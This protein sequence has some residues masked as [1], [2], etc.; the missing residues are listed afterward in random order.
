MHLTYEKR[1]WSRAG[2]ALR[3]GFACLLVGIMLEYVPAVKDLMVVSVL[4]Y[5]IAVLVS[6]PTLG[7]VIHNALG[8]LAVAVPGLLSTLIVLQVLRPP[9]SKV[10]AVACIGVSSYFITYLSN[11]NLLG[12]KSALAQVSIVY[13]YAHYDSGMNVVTFPLR[14][15]GPDIL[16]VAMGI[17]ATLIPFPRLA[18]WEVRSSA[19]SAAR[20]TSEVLNSVVSAFSAA[21]ASSFGSMY[22]HSKMLAKA[23]RE[24]LATLK[25]KQINLTWEP[26]S[27]RTRSSLKRTTKILSG[28]N[29]HLTGMEMAM[30]SGH[31]L[32]APATL[33]TLLRSPLEKVVAVSKALLQCGAKMAELDPSERKLHKHRLLDEAKAVQN[34]FDQALSDARR[35]A[36]YEGGAIE[37]EGPRAPEIQRVNG[38]ANG[39]GGGGGGE[40][41][42]WIDHRESG[43]SGY[44]KRKFRGRV[45]SYFFLFNMQLYLSEALN[46]VDTD[47][48]TA[49]KMHQIAM[50]GPSMPDLEESIHGRTSALESMGLSRAVGQA[51]SSNGGGAGGEEAPSPSPDGKESG[52]RRR[53]AAIF[54]EDA[55][56]VEDQR[57]VSLKRQCSHRHGVLPS[58]L[59][60]GT[61]PV[62]PS[63][64]SRFFSKA[65][66]ILHKCGASRAQ[67]RRSFK[68]ALSMVMAATFGNLIVS[69]EAHSF[70]ATVT[71]GFIIGNYQGG[72]W[73]ISSLRLQG[74]VLGAIYGYLAL[75][76]SKN[77]SWA[78]L[79]AL[80]PWVVLSSFV[81]YSTAYGYSGLVSAFTAA[82]LILGGFENDI[83]KYAMDRITETFVGV[84]SFV[85]VETVVFP[86]R[87][88]LLVRKELV[89]SLIGLRD[90]VAA[91]VAVY[92]EQECLDCRSIAVHEIKELEQQLRASFVKQSALRAEACLEPDLWFVPFPGEVYSNL[93]AIEGRMLD[94]LF[95]MVCSLHATTEDCLTEQM[96]K[97]LEPLRTSLTALQEEVLSTIDSLQQVLQLKVQGTGKWSRMKEFLKDLKR[98]SSF[99]SDVEDQQQQQEQ[100]PPH[101]LLVLNHP[102]RHVDGSPLNLKSTMDRFEQSF[103]DTVEDLIASTKLLPGAP[104]IS[105]SVMLSF[106]SLTFSLHS[107]LRET[108]QL[109]KA[110]HELVQAENPWSVLDFWDTYSVTQLWE[111]HSSVKA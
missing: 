68:I 14:M 102:Y 21:D 107:L 85:F 35:K 29:Q 51:P 28:L 17:V 52:N 88:V 8:L 45:S 79:L 5:V 108:V 66:E 106:G 7:T 6:G 81:R 11:T 96:Q 76:V 73:R 77:H 53:S 47:H 95:F 48:N 32:Q 27:K 63:A 110:V 56:V 92:T 75:R 30:E 87:A 18:V 22:L 40:G 61:A 20:G 78:N 16:G 111:Q 100:Q 42:L 69:Q 34:L 82:V 12:R 13:I 38:N 24:I 89:S 86:E 99:N 19:K 103:E 71:V 94:L 84:L 91:I 80:I 90:C 74:T 104:I 37:G 65:H 43:D 36:F 72:S 33:R 59:K 23:S 62:N 101:P 64:V 25:T 50:F 67:A 9:I 49:T 4:S 105:N 97:L 109:E 57:L 58:K 39:H 2:E 31:F 1:F 98:G 44:V 54:S 15:I 70:W 83:R 55:V 46:L 3:T 10:T 26:G 60:K 41:I 93:I